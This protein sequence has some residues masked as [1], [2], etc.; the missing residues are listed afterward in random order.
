[1]ST[2]GGDG[3]RGHR[4]PLGGWGTAVIAYFVGVRVAREA[5]AL[6]PVCVMA[7]GLGIAKR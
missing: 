5:F 1:M 7:V 2:I 6:V 3:V 4:R